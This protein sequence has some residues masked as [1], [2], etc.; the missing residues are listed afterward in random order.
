M[1]WN[2][3]F[4]I[5]FGLGIK[6]F[7]GPTVGIIAAVLLYAYFTKVESPANN[8]GMQPPKQLTELP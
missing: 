1:K 7:C 4:C 5:I 6:D 8:T 2:A 3:I